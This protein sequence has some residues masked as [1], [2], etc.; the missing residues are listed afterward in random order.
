LLTGGYYSLKLI[1]YNKINQAISK[2]NQAAPYKIP[3]KDL[4]LGVFPLAVNIENLNQLPIK[5]HNIV[6]FKKISLEVPFFSL[7]SK[8]K[9]VNLYIHQPKVMIDDSLL[10]KEKKSSIGEFRI[11]KINIIDG[12]L[13]YNTQKLQV[14]LLKCNL[15]SF[16]RL[17]YTVYRLTCP[18][19][20]VVFPWSGEWVTFE[21]Q[22]VSEFKKQRNSWKISK[23]FWQTPL[24]TFNLNGRIYSDGRM[25]INA[26]TQGSVRQILDPLLAEY[27]VHEFAYGNFKVKKGKGDRISIDGDYNMH[28][29]TFGGQSFKDLRGKIYWD[30]QSKI[31]RA[32]MVFRDDDANVSVRVE[33]KNKVVKVMAQ[34]GSAAKIIRI[35]DI[36]D[37]VPMGGTIKEANLTIHKGIYKGTVDFVSK[38]PGSVHYNPGEFNGEG[39]VEFTYNAKT[40]TVLATSPRLQTEFGQVTDM[41][42]ISTPKEKTQLSINLKTAVNES[43]FLDKYSTFYIDVPLKNWKLQKGNG[44]GELHLKKIND[45]YFITSDLHLENFY[46][47]GEKISSLKAHIETEREITRGLFYVDDK[48]LNGEAKLSLNTKDGNFKVYFN[49]LRGEAKK[50]LNILEIDLDLYGLATGTFVYSDNVDQSA[51]FLTGTFHADQA[52][53]YDF[54]FENVRG[55][56]GYEENTDTFTLEDL[57]AQYM[58]GNANADM[59]IDYINKQFKVKGK[60]IGI[61][62]QRMNNQFKGKGDIVFSGAGQFEQDPINITYQ[63]G[64][65]YFYE[66]QSFKVEGKGKMTTNFSDHYFLDTNGFII[67]HDSSS[68]VSLRLNQISRRYEGKFHGEISDINLL[69]PWG[70][71]KGKVNVEGEIFTHANEELGVQGY[72]NFK[73]EYLSF[74]NLAQTLDNFNGDLLFNDLNFTLR[75]LRGTLGGGKVE[76]SGSLKI[77]ENKVNNLFLQLTGK[78]MTLNIIDR[79]TFN[80][81]GNLTLKY[82]EDKLLLSGDLNIRSGIWER[83]VD[84][85]VQFYTGSSLSP[86]GSTLLNMLVFDLRMVSKGHIKARNSLGEVEGKLNLILTGDYNFPTISGVVEARKGIINFS[87]KKFDLVKGKL[88]F[89]NK[90]PTDPDVDI[91]SEAFIKNYRIKFS[92]KGTSSVLKADLQSSPPL[93]TRDIFTLISVGELF[94]RPTASELINQVGPGAA[95][96]I[97]SELTEQIK[98]RT[99]KILG[100]YVLTIDPNISNITGPTDTSRLIVGKEV[101][102]DFLIVYATNF[103]THRQE[104]VYIQ[105]QLSPTISLIG[106]RNEEGFSVD[107]RFRKRKQP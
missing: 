51:P 72:A 9:E 83:E 52:L 62:F 79:T 46:S 99:K 90:T 93:P 5:D 98:K 61:D 47:C 55:K 56:L 105:Y 71:N 88:I 67:N 107:L 96:L 44:S 33:D 24:I 16:P 68:P 103:S 104:V 86:S 81:D 87:G 23:F 26:F 94:R 49:N 53:F 82:L 37:I 69:I 78:N 32:N 100:D 25:A 4:S 43:A 57:T 22:M 77:S 20:K 14:I 75:S 35:I 89:K 8:T 30:N 60:I 13:V 66:G 76:G 36:Y 48:D 85:G 101:L 12:E 64:D 2:L 54:I 1:V 42:V 39:H 40:K 10:K 28:T 106:M 18:H 84:E 58:T 74:P 102:K 95:G 59:V 97:A 65:I 73:G 91:E 92:I 29:F 70:G 19:L 27:S 34:N 7:F 80:L 11:N 63:T 6:S 50:M 21:G 38:E 31:T 3:F 45:E 17:N 41:Q 15:L